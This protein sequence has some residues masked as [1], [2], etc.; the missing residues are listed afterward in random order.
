MPTT[1]TYTRTT[2]LRIG[3]YMENLLKY[4]E[5][6]NCLRNINN[7]I[8]RGQLSQEALQSYV[9]KD[10]LV[11]DRTDPIFDI[12]G[13]ELNYDYWY[14]LRRPETSDDLVNPPVTQLQNADFLGANFQ[15]AY[16]HDAD[17]SGADLRYANLQG[18]EIQDSNLTGARLEHACLDKDSLFINC[19]LSGAS[20]PSPKDEAWFEDCILDGVNFW[21][22]RDF[23]QNG[24][25]RNGT[26]YD[27]KGFDVNKLFKNGAPYDDSGFDYAG[28]DKNGFDKDQFDR[29]GFN[30]QGYDRDGFDRSGFN[31]QGYD[32]RGFDRGG[33]NAQGY[34]RYGFDRSGFDAQG[35]DRGR[36]GRD[37][38][39]AL[40]LNRQGCDRSG[41][42]YRVIQSKYP[43]YS[44][45]GP[46]VGGVSTKTSDEETQFGATE[47]LNDRY[48]I[49]AN[50]C[51]KSL[52]GPFIEEDPTSGERLYLLYAQD[53]P[54]I[55]KLV[56]S[57]NYSVLY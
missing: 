35:F 23:D 15:N 52:Y 32:R 49:P 55:D 36:Y 42:K 37:G 21:D 46:A 28:Y 8:V 45:H 26:R 17:F 31:A 10:N 41:V 34:D 11:V 50:K 57:P 44:A 5:L 12:H 6:N 30:A 48:A 14:L 20:L 3:I 7:E 4:D 54:N 22:S 19:N 13:N 18:C 47:E 33:F 16:F 38:F 25:H 9:I 29:S 2:V 27:A 56:N 24:I 1:T 51:I 43:I 53:T 40:G 39:N